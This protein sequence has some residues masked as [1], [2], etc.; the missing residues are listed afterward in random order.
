MCKGRC[1]DQS[2]CQLYFYD[3]PPPPQ[4]PPPA[5][6]GQ[7]AQEAQEV[8]GREPPP[9][10][11][12]TEAQAHR[13]HQEAGQHTHGLGN[14]PLNHHGDTDDLTEDILADPLQELFGI[15]GGTGETPPKPRDRRTPV[16]AF[17]SPPA[18]LVPPPP[19]PKQT[20]TAGNAPEPAT[21]SRPSP[22]S[23]TTTTLEVKEKPAEAATTPEPEWVLPPPV[24]PK[25]RI[26]R[27]LSPIEAG[28]APA[29]PAYT[30]PSLTTTRTAVPAQIPDA[31]ETEYTGEGPQTSGVEEEACND[32]NDLDQDMSQQSVWALLQPLPPGW[33]KDFNFSQGLHPYIDVFEDPLEEQPLCPDVK[34]ELPC[35]TSDSYDHRGTQACEKGDV[36]PQ[37]DGVPHSD[38]PSS[39]GPESMQEEENDEEQGNP[40]SGCENG[41]AGEVPSPAGTPSQ[42]TAQQKARLHALL[43]E[44]DPEGRVPYNLDQYVGDAAKWTAYRSAMK[45]QYR[46]LRKRSRAAGT[47]SK[48]DHRGWGP[49]QRFGQPREDSH[50]RGSEAPS[51]HRRR[52]RSPL[53]RRRVTPEQ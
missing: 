13:R 23:S 42:I 51:S 4:P 18:D 14:D 38:P 46:A 2:L 11:P 12:P 39:P 1:E 45:A 24:R 32:D 21:C 22:T 6:R 29:I 41:A 43:R 52:D 31:T 36:Q 10:P 26:I 5:I 53:P 16:R 30:P 15:G 33:H 3:I 20:L 37:P 34:G 28:A 44:R 8:Q 49:S 47:W 50:A 40:P 9:S 17:A 19:V 25:S 27:G 35:G 7:A 48:D